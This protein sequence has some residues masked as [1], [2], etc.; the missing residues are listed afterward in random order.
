VEGENTARECSRKTPRT[1]GSARHGQSDHQLWGYIQSFIEKIEEKCQHQRGSKEA[2]DLCGSIKKKKGEYNENRGAG[3]RLN[4]RRPRG[5]TQSG[6]KREAGV[7]AEVKRKEE[8][9]GVKGGD[10][11]C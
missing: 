10:V 2:K 4:C 5:K 9:E 7:E 1:K 3:V 8:G 6:G 11:R